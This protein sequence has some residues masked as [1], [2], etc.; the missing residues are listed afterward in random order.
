MMGWFGSKI[1]DVFCSAWTLLL[2]VAE[3]A[4]FCLDELE[5]VLIEKEEFAAL[6]AAFEEDI[7][8][9]VDEVTNGK[10]WVYFTLVD[11]VYWLDL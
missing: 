1:K 9:N 2:A 10:G 7:R 5:F 11:E 6:S 4:S 8:R 3:W